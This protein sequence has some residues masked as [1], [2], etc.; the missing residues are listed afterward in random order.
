MD[1]GFLG[2]KLIHSS[3]RKKKVKCFRCD[4][5][6]GAEEQQCP[7]CSSLNDV[8]LKD[9]IAHKSE[10]SQFNSKIGQYFIYIS[11]ILTAGFALLYILL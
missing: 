4:Y 7:Y 1:I 11:I 10:Q 6:F 8:E 2:L 3:S 5:Y 9:L